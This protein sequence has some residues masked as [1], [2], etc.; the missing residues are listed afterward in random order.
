MSWL[1]TIVF[2]GLAVSSQG[3]STSNLEPRIEACP[4]AIVEAQK[5]ETEKFE[6]TYPL[7]AGGRVNLS[8]VNGSIVVEAWE[9]NEVKLEY[10]KVADTRERLADVQ[11]KIESRPDYFSAETDY[12]NWKGK[13]SG[14]RWKNGGKLNVEF[15]LMVPRGAVLN[16][17]ETV[18]GSVTV[19]NFVNITI[20]SA[21]NGSVNAT[22]IRGTAKLSTVNGE[23]KADFDRLET[24]SKVSLETVNG[25]VN[26]TLPSDV[27]ATV[28]ADSLNGNITNDFGLPVRKGKYI[29]RD[30]YGKLGSGDV[31]VKLESVNGSLAISRKND[32]KTPSPAVDLLQQKSKDDN[33]DDDNEM[34]VNVDK[35]MAKA[36][37]DIAKAMKESS[38][39]I[40]GA[41]VAPAVT[42][43]ALDD[44]KRELVRIQPEIAKV[45]AESVKIAADAIEHTEQ[46]MK[47]DEFRQKMREAQLIQSN[48]MARIGDAMFFP[49]VPRV[50]TKSQTIPVKGVPKVTIEAKGCSVSVRGWDKNE[51]QYRVTQLSDTRRGPLNVNANQ[52]EASAGTAVTINVDNPDPDAR[53]GNFFNER[54]RVRIEVYV[55][56]KSNMK[57]T[58]SGEI[59]IDGV[60]GEVDLAGSDQSINVRDVDGKLRVSSL[61]GRIRVIG[62][63]GDI[64]AQTADGSISLE[65]DFKS[66]KARAVDGS[67]MLTLPDNASA[68]LDASLGEVRSE[69]IKLNRLTGDESKGK[70]RIGNGGSLFQIRTEG[71]IFIRGAGTLQDTY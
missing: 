3:G 24:G 53:N 25:T 34:R 30:L 50:E 32:G 33:W 44:A 38:K 59:R 12:D 46:L 56:R 45:T 71:E 21:V 5:D 9:R 27:N 60:S 23:V 22:N 61:D 66:L 19:S 4:T 43:R 39:A 20:V 6:Q 13:N 16:E 57:I 1:Y 2:A 36:N 17:I 8:N 31:Q 55:P 64:D 26:L 51:V 42:A 18:N 14:D 41:T 11:V 40:A 10:T 52:N 35:E 67:V 7:N 15:R 47:T 63:R 68:D 58:A 48:A 37:K 69:G 54:N 49:S 62:F 70:Y 28:R 65:G 29:G